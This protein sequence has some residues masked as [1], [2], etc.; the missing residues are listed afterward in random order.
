MT[1]VPR[2][3]TPSR[4]TWLAG[5]G[6]LLALSGSPAFAAWDVT[7]LMQ[8]LAKNK[9][10]RASFVEKKY[11]A[12]LEAPVESS[13]ELLYTAPD[14]LEKRTLKP[15]PE[16]LLIEGGSL[17]VERGKRRMVLRLQ[18]YPELVAFTESIRG[19][20]AGDMVA[21]RRVYNLDLEGSEERWTLTLR[22]IETKM[23]EVVQRVRI[24]G[25]QAD[26]RTIEIEQTDKD[27]SVMVIDKLAAK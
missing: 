18:D 9:S 27:R 17:T 12:L 24:A 1:D 6:L 10:G 7:Q 2:L 22:P 13:G 25:S 5:A 16:S 20:L 15:R 21:L 8:G 11:I 4:K 23:L 19:T 3:T 14:R 26:V